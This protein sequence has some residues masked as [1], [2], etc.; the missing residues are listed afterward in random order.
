M[1]RGDG[2]TLVEMLVVIGIIGI[3]I[4]TLVPTVK[5][6]Q[7]RAKEAAVKAD[8]ANIETGLANYAQSHGGNYP[9]VALDVMAPFGDHGL[10]DGAFYVPGSGG[11]LQFPVGWV[12]M[13]VIGQNG[14]R[15]FS[16]QS[17]F[18]Q[19]KAAKD[20]A[21]TFPNNRQ[22][23]FDSLVV[24]DS[25]QE[26]PA[27]PF[28]TTP[29]SGQRERMKNTFF[30][31]FN[32]NLFDPNSLNSA[33]NWFANPSN[34]LG[35]TYYMLVLARKGG[36]ANVGTVTTDVL[37]PGQVYLGFNPQPLGLPPS[38]WSPASYSAACGFG[39]DEGDYFSEGDFAYIPVMSASAYEAG[40]SAMT[41]EDERFKWGTNVTG[42]M[43]FGYGSKNHKTREFEDEQR[44]FLQTGLP[45][46]GGAGVDTIYESQALI[47]FEGAIYFS[48]K[49]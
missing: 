48:K 33:D 27:N 35:G 44:E 2:F 17:V 16:T 30:F 40:D 9:G 14:F 26:F 3:L 29:T 4:A 21:T 31:A 37:N 20:S 12:F 36:T 8:C 18:E 39:T 7:V 45:G 25:I 43:L 6:V 24:T 41:V 38:N 13:G 19:I 5:G 22:R 49:Y 11:S 1:R 47:C 46:M 28:V 23:W 32:L 15:N 34:A 42:Y 10:G